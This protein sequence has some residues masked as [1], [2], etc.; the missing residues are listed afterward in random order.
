MKKNGVKSTRLVKKDD[1]E[2]SRRF[3]EAAR[4]AEASESVEQF[5]N[6]LTK[7]ARQTTSATKDSDK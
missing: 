3:I 4:K 1:P 2:Q 6:S 5:E 7:I